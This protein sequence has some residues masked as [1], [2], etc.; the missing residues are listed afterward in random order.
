M[1]KLI[2]FKFYTQ[3]TKEDIILATFPKSGTTWFRFILGNIISYI[4][5]NSKLIDYEIIN[6]DLRCSYDSR[7]VASINYNCIPRVF[8]THKLYS[9]WKF[10]KF[11]SIYI[12]RNPG[13]VMISF[14]HYNNSLKK[15][16]I[17]I[18]SLKEF[19]R[20]DKVGIKTWC[21]HVNS[22]LNNT[23][24]ILTYEEMK[25]D[26]FIAIQTTLSKLGISVS[27]KIINYAIEK[28]DFQSINL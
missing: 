22:W 12:L 3:L 1:G 24:V 27:N 15:P 14:Y 10:N 21:K 25:K 17:E 6:G 13:D 20:N 28:S 16:Y 23:N 5:L 11:K 19:I 9:S 2:F 26:T 18:D 7:E 4:E 8:A